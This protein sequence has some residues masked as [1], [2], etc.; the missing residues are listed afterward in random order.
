MC[1]QIQ[2]IKKIIKNPQETALMRTFKTI[3]KKNSKL[4]MN[5]I[6][7]MQFFRLNSKFEIA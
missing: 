6:F 5:F 1:R 2:L 4:R 3:I 7:I